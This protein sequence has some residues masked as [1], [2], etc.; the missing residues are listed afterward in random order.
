[1]ETKMWYF[2]MFSN[3]CELIR[4]QMLCIRKNILAASID[5][6]DSFDRA[7]RLWE[8]H[9]DILPSANFLGHLRNSLSLFIYIHNFLPLSMQNENTAF[10]YF[11]EWLFKQMHWRLEWSNVL[12]LVSEPQKV[13]LRKL[14]LKKLWFVSCRNHGRGR[15]LGTIWTR[16][17]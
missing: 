1:M 7:I 3:Y 12:T 8:P 16:F 2:L 9:A 13:L 6:E 11:T 15:D 5:A 14:F 4:W 10:M 17:F